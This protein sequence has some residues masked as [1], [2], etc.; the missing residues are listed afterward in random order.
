MIKIESYD[1]IVRWSYRLAR[2]WVIDHLV[3]QGVNSSRKFDN[4]KREG[5]Y[6]PKTFPRKPDEFFK[7]TGVWKGWSDF[8]GKTGIHA[9]KEYYSFEKAAEFCQKIGIHNSIEYRT[10]KKRPAKLP[11]RPDQYYKEKWTNWQD[12]LGNKY[13]LPKRQVFSKLKERDVRI[14]KHQL[15]LGITGSFLAKTFGVSEM[16]IS[17]IKKG[18]NWAEV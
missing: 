11:A 9:D 13:E 8:F 3:P 10:W 6:L 17:R 5:K 14:I 1:E 12:F 4:Y 15:G 18:E 16:Q 7:K 2:L